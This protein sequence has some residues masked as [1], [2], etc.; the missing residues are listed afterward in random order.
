MAQ[1]G[2]SIRMSR[3]LA[4]DGTVRAPDSD[5]PVVTPAMIAAGLAEISNISGAFKLFE[6]DAVTRIY[7]AM[8]KVHHDGTRAFAPSGGADSW[9][10]LEQRSGS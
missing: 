2:R 5:E 7:Q 9:R 10:R 8:R 6:D 4:Q 3:S 1:C